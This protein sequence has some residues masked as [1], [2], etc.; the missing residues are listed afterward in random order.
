MKAHEELNNILLS[1]L[2]SNEREKN[3]EPELKIAKTTP[4]KH[5]GR[6]LEFSKHEAESSSEE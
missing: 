1:K 5:K 4:Y 3:K 6:K 2:H